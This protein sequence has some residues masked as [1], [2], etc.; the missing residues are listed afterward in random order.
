MKATVVLSFLLLTI[1]GCQRSASPT[2]VVN[3]GEVDQTLPPAQQE[4]QSVM[5]DFLRAVQS[6]ADYNRLYTTLPDLVIKEPET[7]FFGEGVHLVRWN[8]T[9]PPQGNTV[10]VKLEMMRDI[11][12]G[13]QTIE[14]E[15]S[16]KLNKSG[17]KWIIA[18][19]NP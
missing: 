17:G 13:D 7:N 5:R 12:P 1:V 11:P 2:V 16:Y 15:R 10:P 6:G 14:Y 19:Q 3:W 9:G 18:R 8:W 4:L